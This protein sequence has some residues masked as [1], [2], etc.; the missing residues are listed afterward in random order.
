MKEQADAMGVYCPEDLDKS[1]RNLLLALVFLLLVYLENSPNMVV[2]CL[3]TC[4]GD[5]EIIH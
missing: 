3:Q 2:L 5:Q 4:L 1:T